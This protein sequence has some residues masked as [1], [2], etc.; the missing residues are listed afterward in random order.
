MASA[1]LLSSGL[2]I[3]EAL[4]P[5]VFC[6]VSSLSDATTNATMTPRIASGRSSKSVR[7]LVVA[8]PARVGRRLQPYKRSS[9]NKRGQGARSES[10][11]AMRLLRSI[12]SV[13]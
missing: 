10:S 5:R 7:R 11:G 12:I 6:V 1:D 8:T 4:G 3:E 9:G 13:M 2:L